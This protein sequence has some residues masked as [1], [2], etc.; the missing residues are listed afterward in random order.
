MCYKDLEATTDE[1]T[2]FAAVHVDP[3]EEALSPLAPQPSV[4]HFGSQC[5]L[6]PSHR[7]SG[8]VTL[9]LHLELAVHATLN[10][11][12]VHLKVATECMMLH[13]YIRYTSLFIFLS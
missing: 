10:C 6:K 4:L 7:S 13:I 8:S 5:N 12:G 9:L 1:P 11:T 2:A 3:E